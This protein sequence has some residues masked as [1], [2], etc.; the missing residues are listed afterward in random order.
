VKFLQG[1]PGFP[2]R[3]GQY[4][5]IA[6]QPGTEHPP[7]VHQPPDDY[8]QHPDQPVF[9]G[10]L[11]MAPAQPII[12]PDGEPIFYHPHFPTLRGEICQNCK[13]VVPKRP[14]KFSKKLTPAQIEEFKECFQMFDKDGDGTI[15]TKELG[16]VM[17]SLG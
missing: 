16:T 17:R 6:P 10:F 12:G 14:V 15:T 11:P 1:C 9:P 2:P 13:H 3:P 8:V 5:Y 4:G 7:V